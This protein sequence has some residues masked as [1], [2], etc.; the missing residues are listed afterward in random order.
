LIKKNPDAY[1]IG[2]HT[3][4]HFIETLFFLVAGY[5][6]LVAGFLVAGYLVA[7]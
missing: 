6:L 2:I 7:G 3:N 1:N 5:L 4:K